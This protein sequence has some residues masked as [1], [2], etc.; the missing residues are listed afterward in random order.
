[1]P[2][3]LILDMRFEKSN[4]LVIALINI[5]KRFGLRLSPWNTPTLEEN[6]SES[7]ILSSLTLN[8]IL[9]YMDFSTDKKCPPTP[10]STTLNERAGG[11][12]ESRACL[13]SIQ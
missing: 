1:M 11:K 7:E 6:T 5:L 4:N 13:R 9:S 2:I 10:A 3:V 12:T 8:S